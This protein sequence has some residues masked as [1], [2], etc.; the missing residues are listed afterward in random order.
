MFNYADYAPTVI[1]VA[2]QLFRIIPLLGFCPKRIQ[3][4]DRVITKPFDTRL[5]TKLKYTV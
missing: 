1:L 5:N 3:K 2:V 4:V